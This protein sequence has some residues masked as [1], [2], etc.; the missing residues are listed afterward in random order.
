MITLKIKKPGYIIDIP[1]IPTCRTPAEVNIS[2]LDMRSVVMYLNSSDISDYEIVANTKKGDREVYKKEDFE[3]KGKKPKK[4][5]PKETKVDNLSERLSRIEEVIS[6]LAQK[7]NSEPQKE[8]ITDRLDKIE[9]LL[10]E[11][12][13]TPKV[14]KKKKEEPVIEELD[15]FIPDIDLSEMKIESKN[16]KSVKQDSSDI[17]DIADVLSGIIKKE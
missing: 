16:L 6:L 8:Q 2:K 4:Q 14:L 13:S 10:I 17:D 12:V 1:G 15:S 11:S 5:K 3:V 7:G 9:K